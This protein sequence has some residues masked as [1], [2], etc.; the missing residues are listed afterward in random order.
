MSNRPRSCLVIVSACAVLVAAL[1]AP[2]A[3]LD[4]AAILARINAV[5]S[6][7]LGRVVPAAL[8]KPPPAVTPV[9]AVPQKPAPAPNPGQTRAK[10][11]LSFTPGRLCTPGD[12][13]F[14]EYRYPERIAYCRRNVTERMKQEVAAHY[15][16]PKSE[17]NNYEFDHLIPL[18][19]GGDSY[20]DNLWPEPL[21]QAKAKDQ[22]ENTLGDKMKAGAITQAEAVKQIYA[23]FGVS[24]F[25]PTT[26]HHPATQPD[27]P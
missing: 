15:G 25:Q 19:I 5:A 1:P 22:L 27:A 20:T 6:G 23:F 18:A 12:S 21:D 10:P 14:L 13:D 24:P 4:P 3:A 7:V 8:V 11:D 16:I 2:A 26:A 9:P 17:W